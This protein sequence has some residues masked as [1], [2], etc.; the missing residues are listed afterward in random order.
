MLYVHKDITE[1]IVI[2]INNEEYH[3]LGEVDEKQNAFGRGIAKCIRD[4]KKFYEGTFKN[5]VPHGLCKVLSCSFL[6]SM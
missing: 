4:P 5:N 2:M 6:V 3:Y 1:R